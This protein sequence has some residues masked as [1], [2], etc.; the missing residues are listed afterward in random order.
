MTAL[1]TN[2]IK[3]ELLK[4]G[5]QV[6]DIFDLVN[7]KKP[8]PKAIPVLL[9]LL[10]EV[11]HDR[12]KEGIIRALAV[13]EAKGLAGKVLIDE[14]KKTPKNKLLLLWAIGN[15][16]EV[17]ISDN[18]IDDVLEIVADKDN[19]MSR[20]MFVIALGKMK[21]ARV[22]QALID[23]L[24]DE[25]ISPHVLDALGRQ[26]SLKARA[27]INKLTNHSKPLIRKEAQKAL[28]KIPPAR[29]RCAVR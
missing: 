26:K 9:Y 11:S 21:S 16:M 17:V 19:G 13:K 18:D 28:K 15:T 23:L 4:I 29:P 20:Q 2:R 14:Y 10:G 22:E 24:N 3:K 7:T 8:Y 6:D 1:D 25:E 5:I 27:K 12:L